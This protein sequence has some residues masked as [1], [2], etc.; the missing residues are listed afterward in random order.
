MLVTQGDLDVHVLQREAVGR[1][2]EGL[3]F[4]RQ[5]ARPGGWPGWT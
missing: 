2:C 5:H 4:Q 3:S 1:F